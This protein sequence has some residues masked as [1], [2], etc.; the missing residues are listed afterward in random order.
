MEGGASPFPSAPVAIGSWE[1]WCSLRFDN[2]LPSGLLPV[3]LGF[4][5]APLNSLALSR[6]D[7]A[8]PLASNIVLILIETSEG[9]AIFPVDVCSLSRRQRAHAHQCFTTLNALRL[10]LALGT[11]LLMPIDFFEDLHSRSA[12]QS[13]LP[14]GFSTTAVVPRNGAC[15]QGFTVAACAC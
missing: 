4:L 14:L 12:L 3:I 11:G 5:S 2:R 7:E 1:C 9:K 15:P 13:R 6:T 10:A 8:Y